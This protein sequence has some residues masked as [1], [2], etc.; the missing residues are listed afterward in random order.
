M[1]VLGSDGLGG[2]VGASEDDGAGTVTTRHV[3]DLGGGVDHVVDGLHG[4]VEGH[5][6][7]DRLEAVHRG[8]APDTRET[9]LGDRG[10]DHSL[11]AELLVQTLGD[12][13]GTVV[14]RDLLTW[15]KKGL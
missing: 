3:V 5:E 2:T 15:W 12:L 10:V 14:V 1:G 9:N 6:L 7:H 4:E 8:A 11:G 13:V